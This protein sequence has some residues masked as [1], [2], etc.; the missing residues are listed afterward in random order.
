MGQRFTQI[1]NSSENGLM[2]S[3]DCEFSLINILTHFR[4]LPQ[5]RAF[6]S[7]PRKAGESSCHRL[8]KGHSDKK[9]VFCHQT[10]VAINLDS[11]TY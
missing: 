5:V 6:Q 10:P 3:A 4:P 2:N 1:R 9:L 7:W 8:S 11:V